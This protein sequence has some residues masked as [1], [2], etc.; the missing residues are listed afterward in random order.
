MVVVPAEG[1][2][3][4]LHPLPVRALWGVGPVTGRRLDA[5]GITTVGD[6]AALPPGALE[7]YLGAALGNLAALS[8]GDDQRPVVPEQVAKSIGHEET[9]AS[10][11]WDRAQLHG[12][13]VRMVDASATAL[14][15]AVRRRGPVTI[16]IRFADFTQITRSHTMGVPDRRLAGHQ[17]G[18]RCP[19]RLGRPQQGVSPA[20]A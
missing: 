12:H 10:D 8:R 20:R 5:L 3:A 11:I 4:F 18:G 7:R 9:F 13:L 6:L 16:K 2:L 14:R 19:A 15:D 17:R 1:E